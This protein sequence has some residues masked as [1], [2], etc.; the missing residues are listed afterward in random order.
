LLR[1]GVR[2]L[3]V[4]RLRALRPF[5]DGRG[6]TLAIGTIDDSWKEKVSCITAPRIIN[7]YILTRVTR[8]KDLHRPARQHDF[9]V[10]AVP[11]RSRVV[12]RV[13]VVFAFFSFGEIRQRFA[14]ECDAGL[15]AEEF[16]EAGWED[17]GE[18]V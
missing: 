3:W 12:E 9:A 18:E 5:L 17:I 8:P 15:A 10:V 4:G 2:A 14:V 6:E 1:L 16:G 7:D 11:E 13:F